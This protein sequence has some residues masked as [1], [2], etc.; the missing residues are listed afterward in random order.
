[1]LLTASNAFKEWL[2]VNSRYPYNE[3]RKTRQTYKLKYVLLEDQTDREDPKTQYYLVKTRYLSSG[4]L[5]QLIMEGNA[6]PMTPDQ[7]WLL[8]EMFVWGVRHSNEW[9][10]EV[11][12]ELAWEVY[13][14][15]PVTRK[16]MCR[17][18]IKP[19]MRGALHQQGIGG[20]HIEV[21]ALL[22]TEWEEWFDTEC[23]SQHKH[24]LSGMTISSEQYIINR[25][26]FTLHH[27][28]YSYPMHLD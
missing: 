26:A 13:E 16:E 18:A 15:E 6:L 14:H 21:K 10:S 2:D 28:G 12:A 22:L 7:T 17:E 20:D 23:W 8:D 19:L 4:I 9:Y 25:A 1:M 3:L 5:E 11:L 24:N 27:G